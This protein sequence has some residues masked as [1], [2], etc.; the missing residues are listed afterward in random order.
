MSLTSPVRL[1][2]ELSPPPETQES[3]V[4]AIYTQLSAD[5]MGVMAAFRPED[6]IRQYKSG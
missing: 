5:C 1:A 6:H 4:I 2:T 3:D